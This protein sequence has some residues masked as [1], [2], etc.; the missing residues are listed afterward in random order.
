V[1]TRR[2]RRAFT[3]A[4][5]LLVLA[6]LVLLAA[7][8][9]PSLTAFRGDSR[10]RAAADALRGELAAARARAKEEGVP[11]RVALS[12][13][14]ARVRRA[15]DTEF[16]AEA[17]AASEPGGASTAVDYAFEHVTA[18]VVAEQGGVQPEPINGWYTV[19]RVLPDGSCRED[20]VL[21]AIKDE[22]GT[23]LYLRVR[24]VTGT[25]R[26][27]PNATVANGGGQ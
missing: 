20:T 16:F 2:T 6:I 15:P 5:L 21:V 10:P 19:A 23:T 17:A 9:L 27:V 7:V 13:D 22:N 18:S 4:E 1:T 25:T 8:L 3:L 26:I 14:G 12:Q 24:G 11:Y